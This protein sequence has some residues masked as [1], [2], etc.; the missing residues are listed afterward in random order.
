MWLC[1]CVRVLCNRISVF[2]NCVCEYEC[3]CVCEYLHVLP[4]VIVMMGMYMCA[5]YQSVTVHLHRTMLLVYKCTFCSVCLFCAPCRRRSPGT[6]VG[7]APGANEL[8]QVPL[9]PFPSQVSLNSL[10]G[11]RTGSRCVNGPS[12]QREH[13][14]S[15]VHTEAYVHI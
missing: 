13:T 4:V 10:A 11:Q 14:H 9:L 5:P 6:W 3:M 8:C 7:K 2:C 15:A 1:N 12:K